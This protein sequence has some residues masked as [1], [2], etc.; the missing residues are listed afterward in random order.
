MKV[1]N[2]SLAVGLSIT[3]GKAIAKTYL[4]YFTG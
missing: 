3:P 1:K 2:H 4:I